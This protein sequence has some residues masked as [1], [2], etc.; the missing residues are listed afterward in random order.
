[1]VNIL[2]TG[3]LKCVDVTTTVSDDFVSRNGDS[4]TGN[5]DMTGGEINDVSNIN[6]G[7]TTLNTGGDVQVSGTVT[8][9][10][11]LE[12]ES[13]SVTSDQVMCLGDQCA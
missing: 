3:E 6:T 7:G 10:G 1:M 9:T 11:G 8:A 12:T 13:G 5:L 2:D 4:M